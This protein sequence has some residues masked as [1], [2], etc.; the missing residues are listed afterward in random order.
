MLPQRTRLHFGDYILDIIEAHYSEKLYYYTVH[1]GVSGEIVAL[2]HESSFVD[3]QE[4]AE[5][6]L[7]TMLGHPVQFSGASAAGSVA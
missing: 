5:T 3:A 1:D 2:G 6:A 7:T 4:A